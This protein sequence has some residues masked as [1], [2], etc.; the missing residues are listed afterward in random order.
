MGLAVNSFQPLHCEVCIFLGSGE[1]G[2]P[3]H[4][5]NSQEVCSVFEH[6]RSETV[7]QRMGRE[8]TRIP[9]AVAG[10]GHKPLD[11]PSLNSI[12]TGTDK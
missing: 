6:D 4:L 8:G 12:S 2:M 11:L 9:S 5:G 3:Q 1:A 7:P 10:L